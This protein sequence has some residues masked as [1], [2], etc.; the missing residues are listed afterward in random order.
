[1][2]QDAF[3]EATPSDQVNQLHLLSLAQLLLHCVNQH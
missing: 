3:A 2:M 1:M